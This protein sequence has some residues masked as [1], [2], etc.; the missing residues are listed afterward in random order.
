MVYAKYK[1]REPIFSSWR[2]IYH[3]GHWILIQ[4]KSKCSTSD[5]GNIEGRGDIHSY[6]FPAIS[7]VEGRDNIPYKN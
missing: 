4:K 7:D 1:G 6:L 3:I 5:F 2:S